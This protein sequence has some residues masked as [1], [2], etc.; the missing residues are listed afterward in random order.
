MVIP[1]ETFVFVLASGAGVFSSA[2]ASDDER[3]ACRAASR[4]E[5]RMKY[6]TR[7]LGLDTNPIR[8]PF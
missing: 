1:V 2:V 5:V 6:V 3:R 7:S 4:T 8:I